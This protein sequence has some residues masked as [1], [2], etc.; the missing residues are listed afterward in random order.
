[1]ATVNETLLNESVA[2]AI[3]LQGYSNSAVQR[4]LRLLNSV[5]ADLMTQLSAAIEKMQ[6]SQFNVERLTQLLS[7]VRELNGNIYAQVT[8]EI[9]Q[10]LFDLTDYELGYQKQLLSSTLPASI[11]IASVNI[12]QV[13]AAAMAQ[14]F[15]GKLL[16]EFMAG[17]ELKRMD[18]IRDAVRMGFVESQTVGEIAKRIRG[19]KALN[20]ADGLL[21]ISRR[22]AEA[23]VVTAINHTGNFAREALY[24]RN[25]DIVKAIR[26]TAT[27]DT[28]TTQLCA[29][30]DGNEYKLGAA[31]PALPAHIR[32]RSLYVP[33]IKS[34]RELGINADELPSSTRAS[35]DGQVPDK[36]TYGDW[37]AKQGEARQNRVLGKEKAQLFRTG[38][39][40]FD[41]FVSPQGHSYTLDELRRLNPDAFT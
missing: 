7:G 14:P 19:T 15:S 17:M 26:Y 4:M 11:S 10:E 18:A 20:Y 2:H 41:R 33:V 35:M 40:S 37:L 9:Q 24:E 8:K 13:Y 1:M 16:T 28:R 30:R 27:L 22:D 3:D 29:S 21:Q 31:K 32:C 23:V 25:S 6:P 39:L 34:W 36:L 12:D 5:D 38:K